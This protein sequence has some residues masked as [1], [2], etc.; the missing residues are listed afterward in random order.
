MIQDMYESSGTEVR[1]AAGVTGVK[2]EGGM[3]QGASV[4]A[5]NLKAEVGQESLWTVMFA[6]DTIMWLVEG[7]G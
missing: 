5:P 6:D 2:G 3:H 4:S 7:A 1:S